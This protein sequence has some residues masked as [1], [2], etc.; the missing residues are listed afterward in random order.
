MDFNKTFF[1]HK[2]DRAPRWHVI[3]ASGKVLGRL[4]TQLATMLRGKDKPNYT[5]HTDGGD[6][7]IVTNCD[8]IKLTGKKWTDKKYASF[9][10]Y[11]SGLKLTPAQD[12]FKKDPCELVMLGVRGMLPKNKLNRQ[13]LKKLRLYVG[14]KHT[15]DAQLRGFGIDVV[16]KTVTPKSA[17]PKSGAPKKSKKEA[18]E[19]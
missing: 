15:H 12:L 8:K 7:V 9:S 2:E 4:C 14:D 16:P 18:N 11:R 3:D 17:A 1:L 19:K 13:I 10:G 6:Y 5:P